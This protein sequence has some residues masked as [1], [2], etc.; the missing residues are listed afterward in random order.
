MGGFLITSFC[1]G[2]QVGGGGD[3]DRESDGEEKEGDNREGGGEGPV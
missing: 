3:G 1:W 2:R